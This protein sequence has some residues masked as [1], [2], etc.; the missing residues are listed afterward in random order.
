MNESTFTD[1][2]SKRVKFYQDLFG[3]QNWTITFYYEPKSGPIVSTKAD[4]RY[5][6]AL[7]TINK[8]IEVGNLDAIIVHELIHIVMSLYDFY[9]DNASKEG[10]QDILSTSR[11]GATSQLAN[12]ITRILNERGLND[13][14]T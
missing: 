4:P 9:V 10:T 6:T 13:K 12:I 14:T 11:E 8:M 3:L 5:Y 1:I 7:V 2:F